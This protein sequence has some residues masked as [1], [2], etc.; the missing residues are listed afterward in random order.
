M[1]NT[2]VQLLKADA[3]HKQLRLKN[4]WR[5]RRSESEAV[6][7][8]DGGSITLPYSYSLAL[9]AVNSEA[10]NYMTRDVFHLL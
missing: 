2:V 3:A 5:L 10:E 8:G 7:P 1:M 4:C 6:L 9:L